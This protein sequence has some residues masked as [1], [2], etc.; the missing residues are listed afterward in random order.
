MHLSAGQTIITILAVMIGT[1]VTR[2]TPFI[3][4]PENKKQPPII[5]YLAK[6]F[7]A[8]MMGLLVVYCLKG[9]SVVTPP[10]GLPEF[11]SIAVVA[12]LHLW[13]KNI[14]LSIGAGTALYMFLVQVVFI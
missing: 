2:F 1:M 3:L 14:L 13:R 10:Y 12:F 5:E 6:M 11:I 7:P 8:A 9:V 4:F